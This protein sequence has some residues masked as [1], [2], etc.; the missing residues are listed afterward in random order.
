MSDYGASS[1]FVNSNLIGDI[2]SRMNDTV[3]LGPQ[4]TI[5]VAGHSTLRGVSMGIL[6]VRVTDAQRFLHGML[7]PAM[8]APGLGRHL[9]SG[10][11]T[12]LKMIDTIITKESYLDAGQ[13]KIPLRKDIDALQ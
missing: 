6:A 3:K 12:A 7:L 9:F 2:E 11:T 8:N 10:G 5:V 1:H 4:A 13:F